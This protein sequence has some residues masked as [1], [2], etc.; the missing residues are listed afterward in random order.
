MRPFWGALL[1]FTF[2][3]SLSPLFCEE[4]KKVV[5]EKTDETGKTV[6]VVED[7]DEYLGPE[8]D[9]VIAWKGGSNHNPFKVNTKPRVGNGNPL[10][11]SFFH[12]STQANTYIGFGS[13]TIYGAGTSL[14]AQ[15]RILPFLS[16]GA[17]A[18]GAY[19]AE[20]PYWVAGPLVQTIIMLPD[21][22]LSF[23][24]AGGPSFNGNGSSYQIRL[25]IIAGKTLFQFS[26]NP[27]VASRSYLSI[28]KSYSFDYVTLMSLS[29][30]YTF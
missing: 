15:F 12:L 21:R 4:Q 22:N 7:E 25:G 18:F 20:S 9:F 1:C 19:L 24:L 5:V 30:G 14:F 16:I 27:N 3:G 17:G 6:F 13:T 28:Y 10:S 8:D 26:V 2:L 29:V 11:D 23:L